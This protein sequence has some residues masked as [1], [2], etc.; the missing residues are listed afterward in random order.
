MLKYYKMQRNLR[1]NRIGFWRQRNLPFEAGQAV[2]Y[3]LTKE[4]AVSM[5]T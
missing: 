5:I 1:F 4:Q 2:G 3:G